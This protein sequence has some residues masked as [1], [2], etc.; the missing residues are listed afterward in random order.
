M[1]LPESSVCDR[2]YG[3]KVVP[4]VVERF[5]CT[6]MFYATPCLDCCCP[7]GEYTGGGFCERCEDRDWVD[8]ELSYQRGADR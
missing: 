3:E 8:C 2:C 5:G 1:T 6:D 4:T 7:C